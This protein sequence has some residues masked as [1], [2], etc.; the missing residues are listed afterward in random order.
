[1][2]IFLYSKHCFLFN[3]TIVEYIFFA[4]LGKKKIG[5]EKK[6]STKPNKGT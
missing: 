6:K 3:S 2:N 1:M 5:Q 4:W